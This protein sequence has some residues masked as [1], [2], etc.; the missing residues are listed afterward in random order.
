VSAVQ[1]V[2]TAPFIGAAKIEHLEDAV[3]GLAIT[4]NAG[5]PRRCKKYEPTR[6]GRR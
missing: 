2:V 6:I 4:L 1:R 5:K 3:A